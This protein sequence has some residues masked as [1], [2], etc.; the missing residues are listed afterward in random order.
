MRAS[1]A[2]YRWKLVGENIAAG[3]PTP[4]QVVEEWLESPG[5]CANIMDPAYAEMGVASAYEG[6]S[7][8][9]VYWSQVFG[10]PSP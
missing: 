2:G 8:K 1:Q 9:G 7:E 3:Q 5:H 6:R 10:T 4:E